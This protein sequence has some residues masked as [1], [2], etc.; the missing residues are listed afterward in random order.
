VD[1]KKELRVYKGID[2][3]EKR[4]KSKPLQYSERDR[5]SIW[6]KASDLFKIKI[7]AEKKKL[8]TNEFIREIIHEKIE[9]EYIYSKN[10]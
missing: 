2:R 4:F 7:E 1:L 5:I 9:L 6:F 10:K 3:M 8:S